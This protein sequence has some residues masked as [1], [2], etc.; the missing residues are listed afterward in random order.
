MLLTWESAALR[1]AFLVGLASANPVSG[2]EGCFECHEDPDLTGIVYDTLEVSMF[3]DE[4]IFAQSVHGEFACADCHTDI[5][6]IPHEEVLQKVDCSLCHEDAM[7]AHAASIHGVSLRE[8]GTGIKHAA[9]CADCH[10]KHDILPSS[11][12]A[13][14]VYPLNLA[15]TCGACHSDPEVVKTFDI[16]IADPSASYTKSVHGKAILSEENFKAATCISCHGAHGIRPMNDSASPIFW[17]NVAGTCGE[18]HQEMYRQYEASVHGKAVKR[19]IREAPTCIDCHGEHNV[20]ATNEPGSPVHPLRVSATTCERCHNSEIINGRFGISESRGETFKDSYHGLA[21]RGGSVEAAN[22]AS[23]H[24][25]HDI[26]PSSDPASKIHPGN[27]VKTC[28]GCHEG[29]GANFAKGPVHL[30]TSTAPGRIVQVVGNIYILLIVI[31]IT[32][33]VLHNGL[34]FIRKSKGQLRKRDSL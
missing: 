7:E 31:V 11:N 6:E 34:D 26:L 8:N 17:Q 13:S 33:M 4:A 10:G 22:C 14:H 21:I 2:Q 23:C 28:G 20:I 9:G 1:L 30:T 25:I 15:A 32:G 5:E 29:A 27:L 24:G 19:G 16:P 3:V 18:C 12:P